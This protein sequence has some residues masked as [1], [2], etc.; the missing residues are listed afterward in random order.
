MILNLNL[1]LKLDCVNQVEQIDKIEELE[2]KAPCLS[3]QNSCI[4]G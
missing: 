3:L 1:S 4:K 2:L